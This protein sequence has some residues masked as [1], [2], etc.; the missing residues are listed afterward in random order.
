[1]NLEPGQ[2]DSAANDLGGSWCVSTLPWVASAGDLGSPGLPNESCP[3]FVD[4]DADGWT[5]DLDCDDLAPDVYPGAP[6]VCDNG[7]D[8]DC[9]ASTPDVFDF[10]ADGVACDLD[11]DDADPANYPGN[12]EVCDSQDN[13][14]DGD[15]DEGVCLNDDWA[16]DGAFYVLEKPDADIF[17][18]LDCNGNFFGA[19]S[20][21]VGGVPFVVGPYQS[22]GRMA[23]LL[24]G[25]ASVPA[26]YPGALVNH[27]YMIYPGG[28]CSAQTI[29]VTFHYETGGSY[30]T[31]NLSIP[32][33]CSSGNSS[34]SNAVSVHQGQYG[35]PCCDHWYRGQFTNPNPTVGVSSFTVTYNDGCGGAYDGQMWAVTVD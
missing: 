19:D 34:A 23:G 7:V 3:A 22:S 28:R 2:L 16:V 10:D 15:V 29:T 8:D 13:D 9:D 12:T 25:G 5:A 21:T 20:T 32:W 11:C 1:M 14:C 35:G 17:A 31:G 6:E 4:L 18:G 27:L 26:P 24:P 30:T 33:D